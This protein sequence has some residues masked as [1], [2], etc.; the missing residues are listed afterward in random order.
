MT[1]DSLNLGGI[2]PRGGS[3]TRCSAESCPT[4]RTRPHRRAD[5]HI[6]S[7]CYTT[8]PTWLDG[9]F[10][11]RNPVAFWRGLSFGLLLVTLLLMYLLLR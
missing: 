8:V 3:S 7:H 4:G 11:E 9:A 2:G 10:V 5:V 1:S 6:T